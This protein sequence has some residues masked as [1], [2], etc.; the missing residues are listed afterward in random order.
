MIVPRE[1]LLQVLSHL[2][3]SID[4]TAI[5]RL[6]RYAEM[7]IDYNTRVNLTAITE[8]A[9]IAVKHFA[10]SLTI[11]AAVDIPQGFRCIDV[12]TGAGFPGLVLLIARPDLKWTLIDSTQKKLRFIQDVLNVLGLH[13]DVVHARAEELG[14]RPDY[15]EQFDFVTARAVAAMDTLCEY[16][17]PFTRIGGTFAAMKGPD[18]ENEL[19]GARPA[20]SRL[21]GGKIALHHFTLGESAERNILTVEK[22]SHTPPKY[23]RPS[24][25]IAK[26]KI[27]S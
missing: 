10:D 5:E 26:R 9:E 16:C 17:L 27:G 20:V 25:Q 19:Q 2:G 13:A 14:R 18:A 6:D 22:S 21:G 1:T 3:I 12:G 24:A 11:L 7:L 8:P 23:P 4:E 15:R